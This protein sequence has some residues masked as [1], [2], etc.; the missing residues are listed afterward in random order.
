MMASELRSSAGLIGNSERCVRLSKTCPRYQR[1][2][3]FF[4]V[5]KEKYKALYLVTMSSQKVFDMWS[6]RPTGSRKK[7]SSQADVYQQHGWPNLHQYQKSNA[8]EAVRRSLE[9]NY[10]RLADWM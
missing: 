8:L 2:G 4:E 5:L 10:P 9:E 1:T 7:R 6:Q 3:D